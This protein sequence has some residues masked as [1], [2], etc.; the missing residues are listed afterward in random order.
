M[1]RNRPPSDLDTTPTAATT[2]YSRSGQQGHDPDLA[3]RVKTGRDR[4][5]GVMKRASRHR[6]SNGAS[7]RRETDGGKDAVTTVSHLRLVHSATY[8]DGNSVTHVRQTTHVATVVHR[9]HNYLTIR[10]LSFTH[11]PLTHTH[12]PVV[13]NSLKSYMYAMQ[14]SHCH[15][16]TASQPG[17]TCLGRDSHDAR[18][19]L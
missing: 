18:R 6:H 13:Y 11:S 4:V 5:D 3:D 14:V 7:R 16:H 1:H 19:K 12:T 17:H 9:S 8:T 2:R 15:V 10:L